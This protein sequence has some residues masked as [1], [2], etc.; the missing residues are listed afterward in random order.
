MLSRLIIFFLSIIFIFSI[1]IL[2]DLSYYDPSYLNRNSITFDK[3]NLNSKKI[4]N[5]YPTLERYY[6]INTETT[7]YVSQRAVL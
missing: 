5:L 3:N 7:T 2:Y 1:G 6:Y 4:K